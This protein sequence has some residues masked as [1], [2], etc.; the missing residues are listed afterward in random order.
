M[1]KAKDRFKNLS[2][3]SSA[4]NIIAYKTIREFYE[5]P[6]NDLYPSNYMIAV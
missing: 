3:K 4:G 5:D 2:S 6:K 1:K